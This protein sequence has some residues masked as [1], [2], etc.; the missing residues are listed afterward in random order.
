VALAVCGE[1]TARKLSRKSEIAGAFPYMRGRRLA[2]GRSFAGGH[3]IL[4]TI[5][6][7]RIVDHPARHRQTVAV[8]LATC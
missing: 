8:A 3:L 1:D 4:D 7:A 2:L 5:I 6:L